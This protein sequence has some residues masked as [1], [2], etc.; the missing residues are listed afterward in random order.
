MLDDIQTFIRE[1]PLRFYLSGGLFSKQEPM[2]LFHLG[3]EDVEALVSYKKKALG[4]EDELHRDPD[5]PPT[6]LYGQAYRPGV[7]GRRVTAKLASRYRVPQRCQLLFVVDTPN[8]ELFLNLFTLE[9]LRRRTIDEALADLR[10]A[11]G[12][13]LSGW[14]R[15]DF[16]WHVLDA[17]LRLS[18][19]CKV[20]SEEPILVLGLSENICLPLEIWSEDQGA[21]IVGIL[22]L[23]V[24]VLAWCKAVLPTDRRDSVILVAGE[25]GVVVGV[26][27]QGKLTTLLRAQAIDDALSKVRRNIDEFG[28]EDPAMYLWHSK[29]K[30]FG[31]DD[32]GH[33]GLT[34]IDEEHLRAVLGASLLV[35]ASTGKRTAYDRPVPHLLNW[36]AKQ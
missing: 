30:E 17:D 29:P 5:A 24:A 23:A 10:E 33:D 19:N 15:H 27:K 31:D 36:L 16:R 35:T 13:I 28:L 12:Q 9:K 21:A 6:T 8:D 18:G 20:A 25:K 3:E 7:N 32:F 22:P 34:I 2:I 11:P 26:I 1:M 14:D 4:Y